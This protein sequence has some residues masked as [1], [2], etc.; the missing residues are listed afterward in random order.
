VWLLL[1]RGCACVYVRKSKVAVLLGAAVR[2][3]DQVSGVRSAEDPNGTLK[4]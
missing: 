1:H 3:T 4:S 2:I